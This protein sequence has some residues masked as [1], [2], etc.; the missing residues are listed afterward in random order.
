M[1]RAAA[2]GGSRLDRRYQRLP[3]SHTESKDPVASLS[4][5]IIEELLWHFGFQR[6]VMVGSRSQFG[7]PA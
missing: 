6:G 7:L 5:A 3:A 1:V 4:D 2:L